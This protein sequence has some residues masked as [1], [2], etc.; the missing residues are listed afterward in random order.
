M[1]KIVVTFI[2]AFVFIIILQQG[3]VAGGWVDDWLASSTTTNGGYFAGQQ[4]GYYNG[5]SFSARWGG[6]GVVYPVTFQPPKI[7]A[8]CGG[9]SVFMGGFSFMNANYLVQKLQAILANAP[10]VAFSLA[11]NTLCTPCKMI[12]NEMEAISDALNH[13]QLDSC[14]IA[15][16][17]VG[18]GYDAYRE[19]E[20]RQ[21]G[22]AD[23]ANQLQSGA[24]SMS[25]D[26]VQ[27]QAAAGGSQL[28]DD[29]TLISGCPQEI[30][31]ILGNPNT[32]I[33]MNIGNK[34]S[35]DPEHI[36]LARGLFG[37]VAISYAKNAAGVGTF[38]FVPIYKCPL[39]ED[40]YS[41]VMDEF[42]NNNIWENT[43]S[44]SLDN[45]KCTQSSTG[46]INVQITGTLD[47]LLTDMQNKNALNASEIDL[48]NRLP[49]PMHKI[50]KVA[51]ATGAA[52]STEASLKTPIA[53]FYIYAMIRDLLDE[54]AKT[55]NA[56]QG[57]YATKSSGSQVNCQ[58][59]IFG[60][61]IKHVEDMKKDMAAALVALEDATKSAMDE[62]VNNMSTAA[63][64]AEY[65]QTA[66]K[67]FSQMFMPMMN[68]QGTGR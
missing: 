58:Y 65:E 62:I 41:T 14:K 61:G 56:V 25:T 16:D 2:W 43:L 40:S 54:T 1:K 11:L 36:A 24:A 67:K 51:I 27:N 13:L 23:S 48:L 33:F 63:K 26:V 47:Q 45:S 17:I 21:K 53:K 46:S 20:S 52:G 28:T 30:Q 4:R 64:Y 19:A 9:I 49:L 59:A 18:A 35:M 31:D 22:E 3:A 5:G 57:V 38:H 12:M 15:K 34:L 10:A 66:N 8:G 50:L 68:T 42:L 6:N 55:L 29:M 44:A 37:D 39:N 7:S 32:S 60:L